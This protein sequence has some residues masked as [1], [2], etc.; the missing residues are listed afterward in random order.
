MR[1]LRGGNKAGSPGTRAHVDL[2]SS[3]RQG[4]EEVSVAGRQ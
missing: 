4:D 1:V 3:A 2:E